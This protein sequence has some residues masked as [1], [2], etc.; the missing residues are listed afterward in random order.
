LFFIK[1]GIEFVGWFRDSKP[2]KTHNI[3]NNQL[4]S[5]RLEKSKQGPD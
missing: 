1:E 4:S 2:P 3:K 5:T